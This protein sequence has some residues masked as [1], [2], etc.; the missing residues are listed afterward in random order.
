MQD[1]ALEIALIEGAKRK[2]EDLSCIMRHRLLGISIPNWR[3]M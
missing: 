1:I 3:V 2:N